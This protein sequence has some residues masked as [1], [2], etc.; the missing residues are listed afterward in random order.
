VYETIVD[1]IFAVYP[2]R[3]S[4]GAFFIFCV[5]DSRVFSWE[6]VGFAI[7]NIGLFSS[8]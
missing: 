1:D 6:I 8:K 3:N 5:T 4:N 7:S 2:E